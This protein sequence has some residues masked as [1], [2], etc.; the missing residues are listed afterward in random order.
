MIQSQTWV[1]ILVSLV[2]SPITLGYLSYFD[3]H[4]GEGIATINGGKDT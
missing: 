3:N 1:N 2:C 4:F